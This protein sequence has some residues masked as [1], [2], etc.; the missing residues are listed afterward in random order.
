TGTRMYQPPEASAGRPAMMQ[1]DVYA[2]GVLLYQVLV[3]DLDTPFGEGWED[4]LRSAWTRMSLDPAGDIRFRLLT[5]DLRA[6]LVK[7][8]AARL[9]T[10]AQRVERIE[11]LPARVAKEEAEEARERAEREAAEAT[12][13]AAREVAHLRRLRLALAGALAVLAVI[14]GLGMFAYR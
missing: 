13:R 11:T 6:C 10:A 14:A 7:D 9:G 3:G 12:E 8:P 1:A 2:L 4:E 5:G